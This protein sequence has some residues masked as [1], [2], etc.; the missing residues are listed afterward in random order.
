[1]DTIVK[2]MIGTEDELIDVS[3][4]PEFYSCYAIK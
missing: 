2:A 3:K 1:M 4:L